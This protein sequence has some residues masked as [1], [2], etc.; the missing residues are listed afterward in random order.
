VIEISFWYNYWQ[1]QDMKNEELIIVKLNSENII[2]I[3][4]MEQLQELTKE[5]LVYMRQEVF[6]LGGG[7]KMA[8]YIQSGGYVTISCEAKG[9][10]KS[11]ES[12]E[13]ALAK[14]VLIDSFSK[15]L[16]FNFYM[17]F[18]KPT[19]PL[20]AFTSKEKAMEWLRTFL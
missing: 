16:L 2:E 3:D 5:D 11:A 15:Q 18:S 7:K 8:V 20:K 14:A 12:Y 6:K 1:M 9:Y 13:Y 19:I 10:S 17:E 4:L